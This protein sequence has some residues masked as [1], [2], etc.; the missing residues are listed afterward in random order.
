MSDIYSVFEGPISDGSD[1][2]PYLGSDGRSTTLSQS[3]S[4]KLFLSDVSWDVV[5]TAHSRDSLP[6]NR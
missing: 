4:R 3:V 2:H 6:K 5:S 1:G